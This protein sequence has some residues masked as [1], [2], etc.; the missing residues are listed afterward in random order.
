MPTLGKFAAITLGMA[1]M[2]GLAAP[3]ASAATPND[4]NAGY[5][6]NLVGGHNGAETGDAVDMLG[7]AVEDILDETGR[8][9]SGI[10]EGLGL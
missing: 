6:R 1:A 10:G 9:V 5:Q 8:T 4:V 7:K 2:T 3:V